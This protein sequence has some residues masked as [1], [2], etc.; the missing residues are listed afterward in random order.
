MSRPTLPGS[1]D[2]QA[3]LEEVAERCARR[4]RNPQRLPVLEMSVS[5]QVGGEWVDLTDSTIAGI[6]LVEKPEEPS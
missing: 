2:A 5:V 4:M 6:V 1:L 3:A